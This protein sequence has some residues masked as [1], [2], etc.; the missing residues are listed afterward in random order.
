MDSWADPHTKSKF[1]F[2][3][4]TVTM[5]FVE[6]EKGIKS[7]HSA[8]EEHSQLWNGLVFRSWILPFQSTLGNTDGR[9]C[10]C[11]KHV[12][13]LVLRGQLSQGSAYSHPS[14][15]WLSLD[16]SALTISVKHPKQKRNNSVFVEY[17]APY[18]DSQRQ[19]LKNQTNKMGPFKSYPFMV[20]CMKPIDPVLTQ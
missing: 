7:D 16:L 3:N 18:N 20:G 12:W 17:F 10:L 13:C 2:D 15:Q 11:V 6:E 1:I 4:L 8:M 14:T 9:K 19:N 5:W